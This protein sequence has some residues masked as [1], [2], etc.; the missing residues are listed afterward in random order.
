MMND[1]VA[2]EAHYGSQ[3]LFRTSSWMAE[4]RKPLTQT[5][6]AAIKFSHSLFSIVLQ[7]YEL[8][9]IRSRE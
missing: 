8:E 4:K 1:C 6:T 5:P 2:R 9:K 3:R 7:L